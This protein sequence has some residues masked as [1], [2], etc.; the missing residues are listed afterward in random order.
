[1]TAKYEPELYNGR[2]YGPTSEF[3]LCRH[4]SEICPQGARILQCAT[5]DEALEAYRE[6]LPEMVD[7]VA[8]AALNWYLR[9]AA[10]IIDVRSSRA[11][12]KVTAKAGAEVSEGADG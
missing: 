1:M 2:L 8:H 11:A 3:Y 7:E 9:E 5:Y 6:I 4:H 10:N 12:K